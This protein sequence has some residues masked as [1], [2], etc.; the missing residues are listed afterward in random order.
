MTDRDF[1]TIEPLPIAEVV[2]L[3]NFDLVLSYLVPQDL[4]GVLR[5]GMRVLVPF[6][7]AW[8]TGIVTRRLRQTDTPPAKLKA[9]LE[10]LDSS[11]LLDR[12]MMALARWL[13]EYYV[14]G[15]GLAMKAILPPGLDLKVS[16]KYRLTDSG[17]QKMSEPGGRIDPDWI[18]LDRLSRTPR[19]L[20][21]ETLLRGIPS[22]RGGARIQHARFRQSSE[23]LA[24][25][26]KRGWIE[27]T[28]LLP[29]HRSDIFRK[30]DE[31]ESLTQ[32]HH[33]MFPK[34]APVMDA[35]EPQRLF[36]AVQA[37]QFGAY[38]LEARPEEARSSLTSVILETVRS[39]RSAIVLVPEIDRVSEWTRILKARFGIEAGVVHSELP[40][41]NRRE[42]WDRA[43]RGSRAVIVGTRMAVFAPVRNLGLIVVEDEQDLSY[44]QEESPRYHARD[45]AVLR[46][47]H[48]GALVLMS[49]ISPSLE[50][51]ANV[52]NG[53][54]R[55]LRP[56]ELA[57]EVRPHPSVMLV[58]MA[59]RYRGEV[60]SSELL[61]A[62]RTKLEHD[63]PVVLILNRKG[64]GAALYCRDCGGVSR[65]SRC[66]VTMA[67]S[68]KYHRLICQYCGERVDPPTV[69][70]G[71][72]GTH[73]G[74]VGAGT[75]QV[76]EFLSLRFPD[77]RI[78]RLDRD[79]ASSAD[80]R[81]VIERLNAGGPCLVIGTQLLLKSARMTRPGLV[82][83]LQADG[84]FYQ[85]DF[86]AGEQTFQLVGRV[87]DF[88]DEKGEVII[89]T[90]HP[91]HESIAWATTGNREL[92]YEK[93]LAA[94]QALDYPPCSRLAAVTVKSPDKSRAEEVARRFSDAIV[95]SIRTKSPAP[96]FKI[97]GPIPA[98]RP[99]LHGKFRY[100]ILIKASASRI[101]H[102]A[103]QAG[104]REARSGPRR[105]SVWFEM[106]V[107][108]Q[109]IL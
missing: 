21:L 80:A 64:F 88:S 39:G 40:D 73:L 50:T 26:V 20:R 23:A 45:V 34:Q 96:D 86:R 2:L 59:G 48:E 77:L 90:A 66:Q 7:N 56:F 27:E 32:S 63:Q 109:R 36:E 78:D 92:F 4:R 87:L 42:E 25:L 61:E 9:I 18:I 93:E 16:R 99:R 49:A 8:L 19:G 15:W 38:W 107:D 46:A 17:R 95:N 12:P 30:A 28:R 106:D 52:R 60:I 72:R 81:A 53:K 35:P 79:T 105:S 108:P 65:C 22:M 13:S 76:E 37:A 47:S 58:N 83:L 24:A 104:L 89:Q 43:R 31:T 98:V 10:L 41:G 51:Y 29:H 100:Q 74:I 55:A 101:L 70:T 67:Y 3:R 68:K 69:C 62:V 82:G 71:C 91:D 102:M 44:K 11:P 33:P 84:A 14:T 57:V 1:N 103:L 97:L 94:R 85:P 6:R 75:E 5:P 54:Y